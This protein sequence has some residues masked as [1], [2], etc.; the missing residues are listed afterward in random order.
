MPRHIASRVAIE[1]ISSGATPPADIARTSRGIAPTFALR[2]Q[3]LSQ[4]ELIT[5]AVP[6]P[7]IASGGVATISA[8]QGIVTFPTVKLTL[9][10]TGRIVFTNQ[11]VSPIPNGMV[12]AP[13]F[14]IVTA[15]GVPVGGE[16]APGNAYSGLQ[17]SFSAMVAAFGAVAAGTVIVRAHLL[18]LGEALGD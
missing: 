4:V 18:L 17:V 12:G 6:L 13:Q 14:S 1:F 15:Q 2:A 3:T 11:F 7:A 10:D 8:T 16:L 9:Y 5:I